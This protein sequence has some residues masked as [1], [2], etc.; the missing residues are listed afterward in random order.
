MAV[1]LILVR[2][3]PVAV[4]GRLCGRTDVPAVIENASIAKLR[5]NL[6]S[7]QSN[8][9]YCS[10][11]LR[12]RQT[13]SALW[14]NADKII[15]EQQLWEQDF[16]AHD[17]LTYDKIP[18]IGVLSG[19]DLARYRPPEG[20][21]FE[22][23]CIRVQPILSNICLRFSEELTQTR[24]LVIAHAGVIRAALAWF[25]EDPSAGLS[26]EIANLS[27]TRLRMSQNGPISI[28]SVNEQFQ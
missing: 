11:A 9:I 28:M 14:G 27:V 8:P 12:C 4:H 23:L 18:D 21:S 24:V 15:M 22:D 13:V 1:E 25:F 10:P 26:F 3:A 17:G 16:G 20:E 19:R 7:S 6:P 5:E 2:H